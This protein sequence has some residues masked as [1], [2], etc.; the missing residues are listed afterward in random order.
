MNMYTKYPSCPSTAAQ[1]L[2]FASSVRLLPV[3]LV[4]AGCQRGGAPE[5]AGR[6]NADIAGTYALATVD[7]ANLPYRVSQEH[8]KPEVRSGEF[9]IRQ[10]GTCLSRITF[11]L[12]G[13]PEGVR[14]VEASYVRDGDR[15]EMKWKG[16]GRTFG[17]IEGHTF[18]MTNEGVVFVYRR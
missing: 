11:A 5:V 14:E 9:V 12:P 6:G 3:L 1:P 15:L 13:R 7:G 10:D 18:A 17:Q 2:W 8:G 16:A 4:L